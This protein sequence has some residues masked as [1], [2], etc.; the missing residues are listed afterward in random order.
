MTEDEKRKL[1]AQTREFPETV[2]IIDRI[3]DALAA[4]LFK[5]AVLDSKSREEIYL[6]VQSL[7]AMKE[8]M[9]RILAEGASEKAIEAYAASLAK[10]AN[11]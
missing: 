2:E 10:P 1:Q 7:D 11:E 5:T 4:R 3:R 9:Q 8:E 6:R